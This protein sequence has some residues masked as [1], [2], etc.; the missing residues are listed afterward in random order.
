LKHKEN[1]IVLK[2]GGSAITFKEKPLKARIR[3]IRRLA[4]EIAKADIQNLLII[5][6]GG[7]FGHPL[8]KEYDIINGYQSASQLI[9]FAKT[10]EAMI[11][12]NKIIVDALI[13]NNIPAVGIPPSSCVLT[14]NGRITA[15]EE[16]PLLKMLELGITPVFFGDTVIDTKKGFTILSGDQLTSLFAL[17]LKAEKI[18]I[19]VD[20]DGIH[21]SDPKIDASSK[22]IPK[23]T[24][25]QI[26]DVEKTFRTQT[27]SETRIPDVT[28]SMR[29]K[30]N[31]LIP[32]V[33]E[34]I[35]IYIVNATK[36]WR[37]YKALKNEKVRGTIIEEE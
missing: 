22:L 33:K 12:L 20:V 13:S 4:R 2:L 30:I 3:N 6:G 15:I 11:A 18:V 21:T 8:A 31:E 9:G 10:H 19:G 17:K 1:I 29:G 34:G 14:E 24:L 35:K 37:L 28:G 36:P 16:R 7:S 32:T 23:I 25:K 26:G 5:H 27:K